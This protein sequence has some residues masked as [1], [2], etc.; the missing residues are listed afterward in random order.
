MRMCTGWILPNATP[1]IP[2]M[3][4][5]LAV[6]RGDLRQSIIRGGACEC[7]CARV[8]TCGRD[9]ISRPSVRPFVCLFVRPVDEHRRGIVVPMT[10]RKTVKAMDK[11]TAINRGAHTCLL[12][13]PMCYVNAKLRAPR[14]AAAAPRQAVRSRERDFPLI[15]PDFCPSLE[16]CRSAARLSER[17]AKVHV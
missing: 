2:V 13:A 5:A 14:S 17:A 9:V 8:Y 7:G 1:A 4:T 6:A 12:I 11:R 15:S 3:A 16:L 10:L